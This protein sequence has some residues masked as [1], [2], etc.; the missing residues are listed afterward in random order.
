MARRAGIGIEDFERAFDEFFDE[1]LISR[2]RRAAERDEFENAQVLDH[3]DRYEVRIA[4]PN[5]DPE[6]IEIDVAGQRLS[7]R[8]PAGS[9]G[10]FESCLFLRGSDRGR[11]GRGAMD[12][13]H[14]GRHRAEAKA[15]TNQSQ[16]LTSV[17][18]PL[19][20]EILPCLKTPTGDSRNPPEAKPVEL[21]PAPQPDRTAAIGIARRAPADLRR[22][23]RRLAAM[24]T[25]GSCSARAAPST[26]SAWQ[27]AS[28]GPDTTCSCPAC[29]RAK[30]ANRS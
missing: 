27:S 13:S 14:A 19:S 18:H 9:E 5:V 11:S 7:V 2:W 23:A 25:A 29:A 6:R 4:V 30:S 17:P 3:P 21:K 26:R 8:A 12:R 15:Q 28:T 16:E 10:T 22:V 24:A 20:S 1:M